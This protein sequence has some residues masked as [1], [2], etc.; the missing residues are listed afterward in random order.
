MLFSVCCVQITIGTN[1]YG[2]FLLF[3]LLLDK[4]KESSPSRYQCDADLQ[5]SLSCLCILPA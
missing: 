4:L 1:Y 3:H 2:H 5:G